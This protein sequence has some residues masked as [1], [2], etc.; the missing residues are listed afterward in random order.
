[1]RIINTIPHPAVPYSPS[2]SVLEGE[3]RPQFNVREVFH[4][5]PVRFILASETHGVGVFFGDLMGGGRGQG[6]GCL[7]CTSLIELI[8]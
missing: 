2:S 4:D 7:C 1:M 8:Y 6:G 5:L 3:A